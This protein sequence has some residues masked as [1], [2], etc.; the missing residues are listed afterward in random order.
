MADFE[1]PKCTKCGA[2]MYFDEGFFCD[3]ETEQLQ[4]ENAELRKE[5]AELRCNMASVHDLVNS[6]CRNLFPLCAEVYDDI[7]RA[8][9][10][11]GEIGMSYRLA[12]EQAR[13]DAERLDKLERLV[14]RGVLF[15]P[16]GGPE[17][18]PGIVVKKPSGYVSRFSNL[19]EAIDALE[20]ADEDS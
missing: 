18:W 14:A 19:R 8:V 15:L 17:V 20:E 13:K 7:K 2:E 4:R 9:L 16:P 11:L 12:L 3:C 10:Y 5:L 6:E 1:I